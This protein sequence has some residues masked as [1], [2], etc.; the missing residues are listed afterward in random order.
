M[1]YASKQIK[2]ELVLHNFKN[3]KAKPFEKYTLI[4]DHF[5]KNTS[6][7]KQQ[8]LKDVR[9]A[10]AEEFSLYDKEFDGWY[11]YDFSPDFN[12]YHE[13]WDVLDMTVITDNMTEKLP[14]QQDSPN[15]YLLHNH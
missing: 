10:V 7:D 3:L 8:A 6:N 14:E 2:K 5:S 1:R 15:K 12:F 4:D 13:S 11:E 9:K